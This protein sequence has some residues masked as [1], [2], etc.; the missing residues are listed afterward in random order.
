MKKI[1]SFSRYQTMHIGRRLAKNFQGG[2]VVACFGD[3]GSGKTTLIQGMAQG[4]GIK[5]IITS[6]TFT[7][8]NVYSI[9]EDHSHIRTFIHIDCYRIRSARDIEQIGAP[10]YFGRKGTVVV[11]EWAEKIQS[12][13]PDKRM[14]I[15]IRIADTKKREIDI[16]YSISDA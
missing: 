9:P 14:E 4:L 5:K 1:L 11:I 15:Y 7:L 10:G 3:L 8:M 6:P 2:E 16:Y 13:L 12:I